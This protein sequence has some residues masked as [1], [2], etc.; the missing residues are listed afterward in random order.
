V[1]TRNGVALS[2][3]TMRLTGGVTISVLTNANGRYNLTGIPQGTAFVLTP[4][5]TGRT[6]TPGNISGT[7]TA[8]LVQD[9]TAN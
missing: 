6:F 4:I 5:K 1:V 8:P 7:L 9:F 3:V 2:G